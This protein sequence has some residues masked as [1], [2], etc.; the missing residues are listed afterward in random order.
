MIQYPCVPFPFV[1]YLQLELSAG[2]TFYK[3]CAYNI[4][5]LSCVWERL[6][7][8]YHLKCRE[9]C[10]ETPLKAFVLCCNAP[11][12]CHGCYSQGTRPEICH[13]VALF[14][15]PRDQSGLQECQAP[16]IE[17]NTTQD[18]CLPLV[19]L[20]L[21]DEVEKKSFK[22]RR[23]NTGKLVQ[24]RKLKVTVKETHEVTLKKIMFK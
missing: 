20:C 24:G 6:C 5:R 2:E 13:Q 9:R 8:C 23:G 14:T 18:V 19:Y 12:V 21:R 7:L 4:C 17:H 11:L 16:A 22:G 10:K 15:F 3:K 1:A